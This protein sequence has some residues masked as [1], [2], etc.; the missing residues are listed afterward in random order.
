MLWFILQL[1]LLVVPGEHVPSVYLQNT[2]HI[3]KVDQI[4][5]LVHVQKQ[6]IWENSD[7]LNQWALGSKILSYLYK[8]NNLPK[9]NIIIQNTLHLEA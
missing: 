8:R 6:E 5:G 7:K 2:T 1:K 3:T 4:R 9:T